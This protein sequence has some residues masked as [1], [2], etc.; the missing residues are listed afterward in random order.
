MTGS[1]ACV[2]KT[3][4][5]DYCSNRRAWRV[6]AHALLCF[7]DSVALVVSLRDVLHC[8]SSIHAQFISRSSLV[9]P[10]RA[11]TNPVGFLTIQLAF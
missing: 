1:E 10:P 2:E 7:L 8:R 3:E 9:T 5:L 11:A 4:D 6:I